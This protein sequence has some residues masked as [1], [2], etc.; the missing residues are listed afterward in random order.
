MIGN[1]PSARVQPRIPGQVRMHRRTTRRDG[2]G[3][4]LEM[5]GLVAVDLAEPV[6]GD[7]PF[8]VGMTGLLGFA[9]GYRVMEDCAALLML[10]TGF[11]YQ[12]FYPQHAKILQADIRGGVGVGS[13]L[14]QRGRSV[15]SF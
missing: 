7:N 11:P 8:D 10:G 12:Q 9:S 2:I 6:P 4:V 14:V 5:P 1:G 13:T 3:Q 15:G